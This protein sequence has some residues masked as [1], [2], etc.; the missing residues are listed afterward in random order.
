MVAGLIYL[1]CKTRDLDALRGL[2]SV[3][4]K[5]M[6]LS[7][8]ICFAAAGLPLL[9]GFPGELMS[10]ISSFNANFDDYVYPKIATLIAITGLILSAV[11][12]LRMLHKVFY[13]H[14]PAQWI[15]VKDITGHQLAILYVLVAVI[16]IFGVMPGSLIDIYNP[17]TTT[18]MD[19]LK[20]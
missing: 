20:V 18:I 8:P 2:G 10:F 3:M 5:L 4:P 6:H 7:V 13:Y 11:Y 19:I 9:A 16:I 17:L 12:I 15:N 14:I 1:K